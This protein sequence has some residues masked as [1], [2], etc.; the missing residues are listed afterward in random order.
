DYLGFTRVVTEE[1]FRAWYGGAAAP[2][3]ANAANGAE[4]G[5]GPR[6]SL[7]NR[8]AL[9]DRIPSRPPTGGPWPSPRAP[10]GRRGHPRP[11]APPPRGGGKS[12]PPTGKGAV[13][14]Y[15]EGMAT[16]DPNDCPARATAPVHSTQPGGGFCM[17]L[18]LAW[19]RLRRRLL[20]LFRPG[21]VRAMQ[22]KRQGRCDG[23]PHD[24]IDPRDLKFYRNV[25]GHWFRDEDDRFAWR[26]RL[27]LAR[28][29]PAPA[30]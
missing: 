16:T 25:C 23:C 3:P 29:R 15:A 28:A 30:V 19:G 26:G 8:A 20:R 13:A 12:A 11:P 4:P 1:E 7:S 18:E 14:C 6:P 24:V 9:L 10:A 21:Y 27:G 22:Q 17:G 5:S 2:A